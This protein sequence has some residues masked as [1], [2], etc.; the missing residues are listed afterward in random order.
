MTAA[1]VIQFPE[2]KTQPENLID[3]PAWCPDG[4]IPDRC[5]TPDPE[6]PWDAIHSEEERH[7]VAAAPNGEPAAVGFALVQRE[8]GGVRNPPIIELAI[9]GTRGCAELSLNQARIL[10]AELQRCVEI[11]ALG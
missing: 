10:I 3:H 7:V 11:G 1:S 2:A 4:D 6:D 8:S 9:Y 5:W